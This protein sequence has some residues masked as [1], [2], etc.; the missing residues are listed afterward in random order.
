P[1]PNPRRR[2]KELVYKFITVPGNLAQACSEFNTGH[3]FECHESIEEIW[4]QEAGDVRDLYKGLIQVAAAFV[5]ISRANFVGANRLCSTALRYLEPYR[6][7]GAMGFD[8]EAMCASTE[9]AH[10]RVLE[11]GRPRL[12]EFDI[13]HRPFYTFDRERMAADAARWQAWGFDRDGNA[14]EL[15]IV[16]AE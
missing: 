11:L 1:Q 2:K 6:A 16:V 8:V 4:Q 3:F 5:H 10:R 7:E 14:L 13:A 12:F 15:E 9:D